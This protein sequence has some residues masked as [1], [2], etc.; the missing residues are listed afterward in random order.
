MRHPVRLQ[1]RARREQ[2]DGHRPERLRLVSTPVRLI[3]Y[4]YRHH[5][6]RLMNINP[7]APRDHRMH[8]PVSFAVRRSVQ[9]RNLLGVLTATI[10]GALAPAP[11]LVRTRPYQSQSA[12]ADRPREHTPIFIPWGESVDS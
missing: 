11:P 8:R 7:G 10:R 3:R 6:R 12:V 5:D 4:S 9:L 2:V 1:P